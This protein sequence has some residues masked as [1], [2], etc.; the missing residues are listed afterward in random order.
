MTKKTASALK[1]I[2]IFIVVEIV[3]DTIKIIY[4]AKHHKEIYESGFNDGLKVVIGVVDTTIT[5]KHDTDTT[6]IEFKPS[7]K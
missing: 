7:K 3:C 6:W 1:V 2:L 5:V 4:T